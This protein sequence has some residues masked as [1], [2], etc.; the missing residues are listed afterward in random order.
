MADTVVRGRWA[1]AKTARIYIEDGLAS[2]AQISLGSSQTSNFKA[3]RAIFLRHC[4][5]AV[6]RKPRVAV[7]SNGGTPR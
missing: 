5:Q 2:L 3:Y 1:S 4:A 7:T 6:V